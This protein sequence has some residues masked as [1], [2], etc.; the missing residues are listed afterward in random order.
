MMWF[1]EQGEAPDYPPPYLPQWDES[2]WIHWDLDHLPELDIHPQEVLDNMAD[3]RHLG[4][5]H[6]APCEYFENEIKEHVLIQRQGGPMTLYGGVMLYTTTW[7]TGPGILLSKQ[8]WGDTTQF[9][10]IANTPVA[11][12]RI[13]AWHGCLIKSSSGDINDEEKA[14]ARMIQAGA[15]EAFSKDFEIWQHKAPAIKPMAMKS[16]GPFL[17]NRKWYGQFYAD[18]SDVETIQAPLNGTYHVPGV[19]TPADRDHAIDDGLPF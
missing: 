18:R 3:N 8:V 10:L 7:Y 6:G 13:K 9:E 16:E 5:T 1:D 12:G 11:D 4:P 17:N 19:E 15:L 2:G 14:T